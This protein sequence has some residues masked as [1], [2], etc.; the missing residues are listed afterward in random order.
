M[1]WCKATFSFEIA[2]GDAWRDEVGEQITGLRI[3]RL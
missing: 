3:E 1:S 2:T